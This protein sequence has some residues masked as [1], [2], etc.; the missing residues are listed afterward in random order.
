MEF[1]FEVE[2]IKKRTYKELINTILDSNI[3]ITELKYEQM[4]VVENVWNMTE[5]TITL[6]HLLYGNL[7]NENVLPFGDKQ[8]KRG[9][10]MFYELENTDKE[11]L[12]KKVGRAVVVVVV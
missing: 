9:M 1:P 3:A 10:Q 4:H 11:T 6:L 2:E 5:S 7:E 12:K 8:F